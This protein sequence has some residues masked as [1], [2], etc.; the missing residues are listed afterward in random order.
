MSQDWSFG[1]EDQELGLE[2]HVSTNECCLCLGSV[3]HVHIG[4]CHCITIEYLVPVVECFERTGSAQ[5]EWIRVEVEL[6]K[7]QSDEKASGH[8]WPW[9]SY[10]FPGTISASVFNQSV[11]VRSGVLHQ[12]GR[13][14]DSSPLLRHAES[15]RVKQHQPH[16]GPW[17]LLQR[18]TRLWRLPCLSTHF[19]AP[20][21]HAHAA[22]SQIWLVAYASKTWA[23]KSKIV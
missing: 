3:Y 16:S 4:T 11:R 17:D 23:L 13:R 6:G 21:R 18:E 22:Q 5:S 15:D 19:N 20:Y 7:Q 12:E 8:W 1:A 10:P 2:V 14:P 9:W